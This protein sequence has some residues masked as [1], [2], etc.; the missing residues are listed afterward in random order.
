VIPMDRQIH[1]FR[2][3]GLPSGRFIERIQDLFFASAA[4]PANSTNRNIAI[5]LLESGLSIICQPCVPT[6]FHSTQPVEPF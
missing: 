1:T 5:T 3:S 4:G 2:R 6:D